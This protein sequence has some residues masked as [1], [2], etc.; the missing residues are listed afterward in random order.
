MLPVPSPAAVMP[1]AGSNPGSS[2]TPL[3]T[4][5]ITRSVPSAAPASVIPA[6]K[7]MAASPLSNGSVS[8]SPWIASGA[9]G[10]NVT[11]SGGAT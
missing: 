5:R 10:A 1:P 4:V 2:S 6:P 9:C 8:T 11:S 7:P 3:P